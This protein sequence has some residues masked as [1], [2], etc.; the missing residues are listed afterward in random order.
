M[1]PRVNLPSPPLAGLTVLALFFPAGAVG[2]AP[3]ALR[4]DADKDKRPNIILFYV[5][6]MGWQ[7]TSVK[8]H[9]SG[10]I[11]NRRYITPNMETLASRGVKFTQAYSAASI[12]QPARYALMSGL[13]P[14]A[15]GYTYNGAGDTTATIRPP[16]FD[17]PPIDQLNTLPRALQA[18]G[19]ETIHIGKWHIMGTHPDYSRNILAAGFNRKIAANDAGQPGSFLGTENFGEP[20]KF[21]V[22]GLEA[23][24][25]K[26]IYLTEAITR[27]SNKE[28][29]RCAA[30]GKPFFLYLAHYAIHKPIQLDRRFACHYDGREDGGHFIDNDIE[31]SYATMIEGMDKSLGDIMNQLKALGIDEETLIVFSSD[32]G[33][34]TFTD[35]GPSAYPEGTFPPT[36]IAVSNQSHNYPL[37]YGKSWLYEG[38][39]RVPMIVSWASPNAANPVQ[40]NYPVRVA[41]T[42]DRP[43]SQLDFFPTLVK[44]AGGT[45]PGSVHGHDISHYFS[46]SRGSDRPAMFLWHQPHYRPDHNIPHL[47][48]MRFGKWK[49]VHRIE[50]ATWELYDLSTDIHECRN[51]APTHP[52]ELARFSR[53]MVRELEKAGARH[54]TRTSDG[55]E[56]R[57]VPTPATPLQ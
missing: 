35:R 8:F 30:V 51:L 45:P 4:A 47:T 21:H 5:D 29:A 1:F 55:K 38:G 39:V 12:C 41:A 36:G 46:G 17:P 28:I 22:P 6:D 13:L 9:T 23:Y 48:A 2:A 16:K 24:H 34:L 53:M 10:T 20:G 3:D 40:K 52:R 25:G 31:R 33:G 56:I 42:E 54:P 27:E 15:S 37:R 43:V 57:P 18:L 32:H 50:S 26:D 11:Y 7:D 14:A 19:Y 49:I 44:A